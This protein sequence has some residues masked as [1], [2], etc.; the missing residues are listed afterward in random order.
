MLEILSQAK[1]PLA[2]QPYLKKVFENINEVEFNEKKQ[3]I[4]M[5]S[6][7]QEK[8]QLDRPIDPKN[9]NVEDWMTE[10]EEQMKLSVRTVLLYSI[11]QYAVTKR[12]QWVLDH[13]GQ[14]VLNG[15]QVHW[16][17]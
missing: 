11:N 3:L 16:T 7:E 6:A 15:S 12:S 4:T 8:I 1:D 17:Q 5:L 14:C 13:P 2:V 10:L 9:K